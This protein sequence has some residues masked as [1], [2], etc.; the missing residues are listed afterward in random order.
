MTT[1][2]NLSAMEC[3]CLLRYVE[4]LIGLG[5]GNIDEIWVFGSVARGESWPRGM[6]LRSDLDLLAVMN[7]RLAEEAVQSAVDATYPLFLECGR[8]I[9]PE[10]WTVAELDAPSTERKR[11]FV[12]N[13]RRDAILIWKRNQA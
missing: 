5:A 7:T 6:G 4:T 9:S 11:A 3:D 2:P 8:Q 13:F 1:L 10:F 12:E